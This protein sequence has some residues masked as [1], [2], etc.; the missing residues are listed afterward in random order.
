MGLKLRRGPTIERENI[1]FA[2]AELVYTT[3][4]QELWI[5]DGVTMG[6][7]RVSGV[8]PTSIND[9]IDVNLSISSPQLGQVLKWDGEFFSP[10][11]V[12]DPSSDLF[13]TLKGDVLGEDSSLIIDSLTNT[14][15][16]NIVTDNIAGIGDLE[17][18]PVGSITISE[19]GKKISINS[20]E[21]KIANTVAPSTSVGQVG[22]TYGIVALDSDYIYYCVADYDG[23]TSIWKRVALDATPW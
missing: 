18:N 7:I 2:E 1:V 21:I 4:T 5:G 11:D 23:S 17:I 6:G 12:L 20:S 15:S 10:A 22:D 19:T 13:G 3:D 14:I 16:G 8:I 9:L